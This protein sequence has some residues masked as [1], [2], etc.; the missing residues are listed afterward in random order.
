MCS[1]STT[2][3]TP[4]GFIT[5]AIVAAASSVKRSC[6]WGS[7]RQ[8]FD[9]A[10]KLAGAHDLAARQVSHVR[11]TPKREQVV[12]AHRKELNVFQYYHPLVLFVETCVYGCSRIAEETGK[13]KRVRLRYAPRR[14]AQALARRIL[15]NRKQDFAYCALNAL[16]VHRHRPV[17]AC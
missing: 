15:S 12:L 8:R 5:L 17:V 6:S 13:E 16:G 14:F 4:F 2:T 1:A 3:A 7:L 11:Y 9:Y 10:S